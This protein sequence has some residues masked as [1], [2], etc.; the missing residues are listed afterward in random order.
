MEI[1][2]NQNICLSLIGKYLTIK[3]ISDFSNVPF[4]VM[5]DR[6]TFLDNSGNFF[7]FQS[8]SFPLDSNSVV[9]ITSDGSNFYILSYYSTPG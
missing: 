4:N 5:T 1:I 3:N 9:T 8:S 7:D 6:S 2:L